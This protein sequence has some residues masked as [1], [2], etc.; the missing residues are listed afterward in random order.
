MQNYINYYTCCSAVLAADIVVDAVPGEAEAPSETAGEEAEQ[1]E[2]ED[3]GAD[4]GY[5]DDVC[6]DAAPF[7]VAAFN[8]QSH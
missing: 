4:N 7:A 1:A 6:I 8:R 2:E 3:A 5:D